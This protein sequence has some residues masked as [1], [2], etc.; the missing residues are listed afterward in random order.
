MTTTVLFQQSPYGLKTSISMFAGK[1]GIEDIEFEC[2][3]DEGALNSSEI[4]TAVSF[5]HDEKMVEFCR[6]IAS[7]NNITCTLSKNE[8]KSIFLPAALKRAHDSSD[9][10][11]STSLAD[12][13]VYSGISRTIRHNARKRWQSLSIK[14]AL[15]VP[16]LVSFEFSTPEVEGATVE[17]TSSIFPI[18]VKRLASGSIDTIDLLQFASEKF[19]QEAEYK[20]MRADFVFPVEMMIETRRGYR[21]LL[22]KTIHLNS[23]R[24]IIDVF[25]TNELRR[26]EAALTPSSDE[27]VQGPKDLFQMHPPPQTIWDALPKIA[28]EIR[29]MV[30]NVAIVALIAFIAVLLA[31][32]AKQLK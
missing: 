25:F 9:L 11:E 27:E 1:C 30:V 2:F 15:K 12:S 7:V 10:I 13:G 3:A 23:G 14:S 32:L 24:T 4:M 5:Q 6:Y 17:F 16:S 31:D 29:K 20:K 26:L 8:A 22:D 18:Q 21:M 28:V 19:R